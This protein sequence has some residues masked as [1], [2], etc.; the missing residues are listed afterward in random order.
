MSLIVQRTRGNGAQQ[1][2]PENHS[3]NARL[4]IVE[5]S[6]GEDSSLTHGDSDGFDSEPPYDFARPS[7][8]TPESGCQ[9]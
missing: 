2:D 5:A 8:P 1:E 9:L 6:S 3:G 7:S 4:E